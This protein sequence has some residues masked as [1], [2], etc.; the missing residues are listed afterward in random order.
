M[1]KLFAIAL[2]LLTA[3]APAQ[4]QN[5]WV[6]VQ[7]RQ[8][9]PNFTLNGGL[10]HW[11]ACRAKVIGG[12]A[13]CTVLIIGE[14]TPRG[15]GAMFNGA[16]NDAASGAWP[17][18]VAVQLRQIYGFNAQAN[19]IAGS[20]NVG[21]MATFAAYDTRVVTANNW[22]I[23]SVG[24]CS[25]N[26][27]FAGGCSF[28]AAANDTTAFEFNPKNTTTYPSAPTVPTN[29]LD[30]YSLN[31][32]LSAGFGNLSVNVNGGSSLGTINQSGSGAVTYTK[33]TITTGG[34]AVDNTWELT[35]TSAANGCFFDAIVA[36][37]SAVPEAS[38]ID[39]GI[40]GATVEL[41]ATPTSCNS[42]SCPLTAIQ[43]TYKPD[44]CI[45]Q[46]QGNDQSAGTVIAT[47]K[48]NY[49]AIIAACQASG[50]ALIV[51]SQPSNPAFSGNPTYDVQ[52]TYVAAQQQIAAAMNVPILDW[53][54]TMCGTVS[55]TGSGSTCSRGGW[56]AG[57]ANGWNGSFNGETQDVDHQG[58]YAYAVLA[59]Q[60]A[61][62]LMQ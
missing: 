38:F 47:Y 42:P 50:D 41:W 43:N 23:Y 57:I 40:G 17:V 12:T 14:S 28:E 49:E 51:T 58:P 46:D 33:T 60:V 18:Q 16:L 2:S 21:N 53:W 48:T 3:F 45:I 13:N 20:G 27:V 24:A 31:V 62:I 39:M 59:S 29:T 1:K 52:Q 36:R 11:Q 32:N 26:N 4:A 9:I 22:T 5:I 6:A 15:W 61:Q 35:C 30:V 19:S 8:L 25:G 34:T 37:N 55:G 10:P 54:T 44:L 7:A 56:T